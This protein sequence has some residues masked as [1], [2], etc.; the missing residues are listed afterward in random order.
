MERLVHKVVSTGSR[1]QKV[2]VT[3]TTKTGYGTKKDVIPEFYTTK[4]TDV[5]R[6]KSRKVP[7]EKRQ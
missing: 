5:M 1:H 4:E 7:T 2:D 6:Q 3:G